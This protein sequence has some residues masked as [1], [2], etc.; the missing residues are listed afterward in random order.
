MSVGVRKLSGMVYDGVLWCHEG[1]REL[2]DGVRKASYC[3]RK[4]LGRCY[5]E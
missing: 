5:K 3:V 1:I 2:V 4:M